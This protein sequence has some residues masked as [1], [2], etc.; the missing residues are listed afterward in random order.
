MRTNVYFALLILGLIS[1]ALSGVE[2]SPY[3]Q[4]V[5]C[6]DGSLCSDGQSCCILASGR[7]GCCP[8]PNAVCCSDR[9]HCCPNGYTCDVSAGECI[10]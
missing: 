10:K 8:L 4:S 2:S 1:L 6:H 7:S 9:E 5:D 3:L